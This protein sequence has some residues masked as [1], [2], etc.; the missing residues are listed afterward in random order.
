MSD[1][2]NLFF[3]KGTDTP[4][5]PVK[6][7]VKEPIV[8]KTIVMEQVVDD[9]LSNSA[10]KKALQD[11]IKKMSKMTVAQHTL[12]E[13]WIELNSIKWSDKDLTL[14]NDVKENIW[15]P[16]NPDDYLTLEP[17]VILADGEYAPIWTML[18]KLT[19]TMKWSQSPGRFAK[20]LVI[21]D[22]TKKYL[23]VISIASDFISV[24]G[25]D[26]Y[27][28]WKKEDKMDNGRLRHTCMASSLVPTQPLGYNYMGGKLI[29]LMTVSN[30]IEEYWNEKYKDTLVGVTTTSLYGAKGMS[31]YTGLKY[32][33][34]C[35]F[36]EGKIP[37]EPSEETYRLI[38]EWVKEKH[39]DYYTELMTPKGNGPVSHVR[40]RLIAFAFKKLG[41][42][43]V[44]NNFTRGV[45]FSELYRNTK[46]FLSSKDNEFKE[47]KFDNSVKALSDVWKKHYARKRIA[48]L[49]REGKVS[50]DI[51]FYDDLIGAD[52]EYVE[53]K[54][55]KDIGR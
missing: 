4:K 31:Q 28:G 49:Q 19:S 35:K 12:Y 41:V 15:I 18:R 36:T 25:R 54:Y 43:P 33:H 5:A 1:A 22:V 10:V 29:S 50:N 9:D 11:N 17:N 39:N 38:K 46:D 14:L 16:N 3:K 13:K 52:F 30:V 45:Y 34:E 24:G 51:L 42:K 44:N 26:S 37:I 8:E 20:F 2:L 55:L 6:T 47:K 48:K 23:G 32:W 21:D 27:I 53:K 7:S 40:P